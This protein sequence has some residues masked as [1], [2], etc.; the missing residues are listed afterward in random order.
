M[1][2]P[3]DQIFYGH[4]GTSYEI[5]G[6]TNHTLDSV[7]LRIC[8]SI[9]TPDPTQKIEPFLVN[10]P[11]GNRLIMICGQEGKPDNTGRT[12]LLFHALICSLEDAEKSGLNAFSLFN[13]GNIFKK[14]PI[15]IPD[16]FIFPTSERTVSFNTE[17]SLPPLNQ[18]V[19]VAPTALNSQI[20]YLLGERINRCK[21]ASFTWEPLQD[22]DLYV[23]WDR[24]RSTVEKMIRPLPARRMFDAAPA[25]PSNDSRETA[26]THDKPVQELV[27]PEEE[28]EKTENPPEKNNWTEIINYGILIASLALNIFLLLALKNHQIPRM[29]VPPEPPIKET[30]H[31]TR[32]DQPKPVEGKKLSESEPPQS[33]PLRQPN[34]GFKNVK[35]LCNW[36]EH[37]PQRTGGSWPDGV[38][39]PVLQRI[40]QFLNDLKG[41]TGK[42]YEWRIEEIENSWSKISQLLPN[43]SKEREQIE[44]YK[45]GY[46]IDLE[47]AHHNSLED[48]KKRFTSIKDILSQRQFYIYNHQLSQKD[49]NDLDKSANSCICNIIKKNEGNIEELKSIFD[50]LRSEKQNLSRDCFAGTLDFVEK[51]NKLKCTVRVNADLIK[52]EKEQVSNS[53]GQTVNGR[54]KIRVDSFFQDFTFDPYYSKPQEFNYKLPPNVNVRQSVSTFLIN[55]DFTTNRLTFNNNPV[56]NHDKQTHVIVPDYF[57]LNIQFDYN[58]EGKLSDIIREAPYVE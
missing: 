6:S 7:I 44:G 29:A 55:F 24:S 12:T 21:W 32:V 52:L 39:V 47:N 23:L 49:K 51:F 34:Q 36:I 30:V 46:I 4:T 31:G 56:N 58:Q 3:F 26:H 43:P 57:E 54:N 42:T 25:L 17:K 14:A 40:D 48:I 13:K 28:K 19:L 5:L 9:G 11:M 38:P 1:E 41:Q 2:L 53:P 37:Q 8:E 33:P 18:I 15:P 27:F 16:R 20:P 22:F 50:D 35:E 45:N 10:V